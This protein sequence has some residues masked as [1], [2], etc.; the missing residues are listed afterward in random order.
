MRL[1]YG[2]TTRLATATALLVVTLVAAMVWQWATTERRL[3][4]DQKRA[5]ARALATAMADLFMNELDDENWGQVRVSTELL[6]TRN[7]DVVY[8]LVHDARRDDLVVAAAP[9]ELAGRY[10]PDLVPLAV[11]RS[12]T[13]APAVRTVETWLLRDVRI[14]DE[15]RAQRGERVAEVAVP[16]GTASGVTVGS[17]RIGV[18]LAAVDRAAAAAIR[19]ALLIGAL[20]LVLGVAGAIGLARRLAAPVRWLAHDAAKIAAGD[21]GHRARVTRADEIGQLAEGFNDMAGA[22]EGSFGRLRKTLASFERFV[23]RK[24]LAVVAPEGI[25]NIQ[26]GT[27][28]TRTVAVLFSDIRGFTRMSEG[29]PPLKVYAMLNDYLERMGKAI[30]DAG[31]FVDKYIGDAIMALFD[32]EH[33]DRLLDAILAMRAEL[34]A[35]NTARV[36]AGL[37]PIANGI[38]A[39][40]GEV[41]MGTIGFASKIESTVIG[42]AVNVAS[43]VEGLTKDHGVAV[44]VTDAVVARLREPGKYRLRRVAAQVVLRGRVDPVDLFTVDDEPAPRAV[45]AGGGPAA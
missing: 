36:A 2:L 43:R 17:L 28:A 31:G 19:R 29:M 1:R 33:T 44:L 4:R 7:P 3:V 24:F 13:A 34:A 30:D 14:G 40:G 8:V 35:L 12:A 10:V 22:L 21:L 16:V 32:D 41:V 9:V 18:S 45:S 23:P 37:P 27:S 26:V 11:T 25:E 20:A 5:E 39:H 6:L 15:R 38:G 42:D